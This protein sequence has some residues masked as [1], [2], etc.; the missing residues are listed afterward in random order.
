MADDRWGVPSY[1]G[2]GSDQGNTISEKIASLPIVR[3]GAAPTEPDPGGGAMVARDAEPISDAAPAPEARP[4][5]SSGRMFEIKEDLPRSAYENM[6]FTEVLPRAASNLLPSVGNVGKDLYDAVYNYED[7]AGSINQLGKGLVSKVRGAF[8]G[9]RNMEAEAVADALGAMYADRYGSMAGFKEALAEDPASITLD[10]ASVAPV[11][12]ITG[13]AAGLGKVATGIERAASLG[14]PVNLAVQTAKLG[15]QA[16]TR[17]AAFASRVTQGIASGTP[18]ASLSLAAQ[19][20]RSKDPLARTAFRDFASGKGDPRDIARAA[21]AAMEEKKRIASDF[22]TSR[23]RELTTQEL[24]LTS[25]RDALNDAMNS[26]NRYGTRANS[27]QFAALQK[28][29]AM[30]RQYEAHPNPA[31]RTAV[32]LDLLKRDLHDVV[33]QLKPSD[34]GAIAGVPRAVKDTISRVDPTYAQMMDYW[35]EWMGKMRDLQSTLGTGDRV[36]ETARIGKL[37]STMKRG[38][39][40]NLLKELADTPSGKYL[41]YMIAGSTVQDLLPPSLQAF[42]MAGLGSVALGGLHGIGAAALASPKLAGMTQYGLGRLE[43]AVGSIPAPPAIATNA[44]SQIGDDRI[45]RKSGGRVGGDHMVAADQLVRAAERAKK[46]LGRST[47]PLLNQSDDAVAHALEV[48]NR[49]I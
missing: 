13:R 8:G 44:L 7:T 24:S 27:E 23:R 14:D 36:S 25:V 34:R 29:E 38:E 43:G 48:A 35:R 12:G 9:E 16:V 31:A 6:P 1:L 11:V 22:Y 28:M 42:G 5:H 30:V 20:G 41:P 3:Q 15:T 45:G 47:E 2:A 17:P 19:A 26:V 10:A 46:E 18:Q 39:K 21:M 32:E 4:A 40:I 49:S 37:M 33:D